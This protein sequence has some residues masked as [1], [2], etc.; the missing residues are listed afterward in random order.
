MVEDRS[1][2]LF[3]SC[4]VPS[5]ECND[6]EII[7]KINLQIIINKFIKLK[8]IRILKKRKVSLHSTQ[9][10]TLRHLNPRVL[11]ILFPIN[12]NWNLVVVVY[13]LLWS[14]FVGVAEGA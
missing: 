10:G 5:I 11:K 8:L 7:F 3:V 13:P 9:N 14:L 2:V 12:H 1:S 6:V 4:T